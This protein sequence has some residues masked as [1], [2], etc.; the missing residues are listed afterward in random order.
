MGAAMRERGMPKMEGR[1]I[2]FICYCLHLC[3]H[4][5]LDIK[6]IHIGTAEQDIFFSICVVM[7]HC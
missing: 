2:K 3:L 7:F 1:S 4:T 6:L 5:D